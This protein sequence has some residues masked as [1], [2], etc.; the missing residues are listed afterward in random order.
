MASPELLAMVFRH[1]AAFR[2]VY[3][4]R[5]V[6]NLYLDTPGL[7]SYHDHVDGA[8]NRTKTRIRW[9]GPPKPEIDKPMLERKTKC[10]LVSGKISEALPGFSVNGQGTAAMVSELLAR[11]SITEY[12]RLAAQQLAPSLFNRYHRRYFLSADGCYRLTIDSDL[13][14]GPPATRSALGQLPTF[15]ALVLE[16]K[17]SALHLDGASRVTNAF[18]FRLTR[19]SK[20]VLGIQRLLL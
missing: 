1:P 8:A 19:F 4:A 6:N 13:Q 3:P 7:R 16:L 18:P 10:G 12:S 9:Y 17:F 15:P 11:S 2:E 14:F 20:Y 5:I